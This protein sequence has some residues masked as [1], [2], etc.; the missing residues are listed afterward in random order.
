MSSKYAVILFVIMF[1]GIQSLYANA[2]KIKDPK[3]AAQVKTILEKF[4][5][6]EYKNTILELEH[7]ETTLRTSRK[8]TKNLQGLIYYWRAITYKRINEFPQALDYFRKAIGL[9]VDIA[10]VYYEYAQT[11]YTSEE[12]DKAAVAF[13]I[14]AKK[15]YKRAVSLYYLAYIQQSLKNYKQALKAYKLIEKTKD[16]EKEE[17]IQAV[18]MQIGDIYYE[19]AKN[20][21]D[22]V[23]AMEDIVVPQYKRALAINAESNISDEI[24]KKILEIKRVFELVMFK[25]RNG[26]P[27]V[28]PPYFLRLSQ[29]ITHDSNVIFS[30]DDTAN[31]TPTTSS[32]ISRTDVMGRYTFYYKNYL[33][34]APELRG[35]YTRHFERTVPQIFANDNYG[36]TVALRTY[37]EVTRFNKPASWLFDYE[38]NYNARDVNQNKSLV[39]NSKAHVLMFGHRFNYFDRG[40]SIVRYRLRNTT[41]QNDQVSSKTHS[42]TFEQSVFMA[43]GHTLLLFNSYDMLRANDSNNDNNTLTLRGDYIMPRWFDYATPTF[44]LSTSIVDTMKQSSTRGTE[45]LIAPSFRLTKTFKRKF[46][47]NLKYEYSQNSSDDPNFEYKKHVYGLDFEYLF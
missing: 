4:E 13:R 45:I 40:E 33:A 9:N 8:M 16:P 6:G 1:I 41:N 39:F 43:A 14:S 2:F 22:A 11:L 30:P 26:R 36:Y 28:Q 34:I 7:F 21:R 29:G 25:L 23:A 42:F 31:N 24:K 35:S 19:L 44:A 20:R 46:R 17:I 12:L 10:D 18:Q 37:Y 27:T 3:A 15:N 38:Y 32:M 47:V 5:A